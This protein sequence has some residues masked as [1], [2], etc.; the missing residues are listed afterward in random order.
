[1][2]ATGD[3]CIH[4]K[5]AFSCLDSLIFV[6]CITSYSKEMMK[7]ISVHQNEQG[8]SNPIFFLLSLFFFLFSSPGI[9]SLM[10]QGLLWEVLHKEINQSRVQPGFGAP[11]KA[12][13]LKA[14]AL[15]AGGD[16]GESTW[17][18]HRNYCCTSNARF[19][20]Q[21]HSRKT[22]MTALFARLL[23]LVA[24]SSPPPVKSVTHQPG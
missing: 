7:K 13:A 14:H 5:K 19:I 21:F 17:L 16:K 8:W 24:E 12:A 3:H 6:L 20:Y 18:H 2:R 15:I 10:N 22:H 23:N 11:G 4:G 1:M 9:F